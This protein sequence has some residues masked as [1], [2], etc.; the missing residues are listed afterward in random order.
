MHIIAKGCRVVGTNMVIGT[1][2]RAPLSVTKYVVGIGKLSAMQIANCGA[3]LV[4]I[5]IVD[6]FYF[7]FLLLISL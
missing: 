5:A 4:T 2:Y 6:L 3:I 7:Y 1:R